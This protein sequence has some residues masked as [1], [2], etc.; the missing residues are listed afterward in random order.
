MEPLSD[1][2]AG[3][4]SSAVVM[5][6]TTSSTPLFVGLVEEPGLWRRGR[7][8]CCVGAEEEDS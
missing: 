7:G 6:G 3:R 4:W 8:R 1:I 2:V 5:C